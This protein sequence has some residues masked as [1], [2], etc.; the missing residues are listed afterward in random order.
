MT[1]FGTCPTSPNA[2]CLHIEEY[3]CSCGNRWTHS[4]PLLYG[5]G[6]YGGTPGPKEEN[7]LPLARVT[8]SSRTT[9][10]CFRCVPVGTPRGYA[11]APKA[12]A[13]IP[14]LSSIED[15]IFS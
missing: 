11:P 2:L 14:S 10:H 3:S 9:S 4:Y 1:P 7:T 12:R 13:A 5:N 6:H 15:S 8:S